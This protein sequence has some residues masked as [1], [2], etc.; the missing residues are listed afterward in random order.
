MS[1][2][3][4]SEVPPILLEAG[5]GQPVQGPTGQPMF[6]K[7]GST[8]THGSY[9]AIEYSHAAGAAGPPPH[10][11]QEHEE[12]FIVIDGELTL[13]VG[14]TTVTVPRG[15]FALVPRGTVH[16]PRNDSGA[17]TRFIFITSPP[18]EGFFI[19]MEQLLQRHNGRPPAADLI[20]IG[21]RWDCTFV[22][23]DPQATVNMHNE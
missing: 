16:Q 6:I 20:E 14:D 12:A 3:S 10:V 21:R 13:M 1:F 8:D 18:F 5:Q 2:F 4:Q 9:A 7:A 19:E 15:G 22:D 23:L 11:H 17:A